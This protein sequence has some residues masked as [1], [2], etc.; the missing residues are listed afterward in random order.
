MRQGVG[1][2]STIC[3][4]EWMTVCMCLH[5]QRI[6]LCV[7]IYTHRSYLINLCVASKI[8][9]GCLRG[10]R[11]S[12]IHRMYPLKGDWLLCGIYVHVLA[13]QIRKVTKLIVMAHPLP[14]LCLAWSIR[15]QCPRSLG[16]CS[17]SFYLAM[18][19]L[20]VEDILSIDMSCNADVSFVACPT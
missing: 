5:L 18:S 7:S 17:K 12:E 14:V 8:E 11:L 13:R 15:W 1:E 10:V 20:V 16:F 4:E 19:E 3:E 6:R 9:L 2:V